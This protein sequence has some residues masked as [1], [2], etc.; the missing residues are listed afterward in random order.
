MA[1]GTD[2]DPPV[3]ARGRVPFAAVV[4][5]LV[6]L[7]VGSNLPTPLYP[8][9]A[10]VFHFSPLTLTLVYST[11]AFTVMAGLLVFGSSSDSLGRRRVLVPALVLGTV[12]AGLFAAATNLAWLFVAQIVEGVAMAALQG[13]ALPALMETEP[14]GDVL[15][16]SFVAATA[17][18]G[19]AALGPLVAGTLA[20]YLPWPRQLCFLLVAG[21]TACAA[22]S[23]LR[24]L[25]PDPRPTARWRPARP[26]VPRSMR[27][28]F[29]LASATGG[30]AW[31]VASLFLSLV[32]SYVIEATGSD[33]LAV[34]GAA[35]ALMLACS[36]T[37]QVLARRMAPTRAQL[38]GI[39]LVAVSTIPLV[40]VA[41]LHSVGVVL[42][43][44]VLAGC[45]H[46]LAFRGSLNEIS[47]AAPAGR[48][49]DVVA[50]FFLIVYLATAVPVIGVGLLARSI[51]LVRAVEVFGYAAGAVTAG[52]A[53]VL[54]VR[55][56]RDRRAP[57]GVAASPEA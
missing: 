33:N 23:T 15:R 9:Y 5:A 13:S 45:G 2:L 56:G 35:T 29:L 1:T 6:V 26:T 42:A 11:Y 14:S 50:S 43:A 36:A 41:H 12:A 31:T 53:V 51:T 10:R 46:G 37:V 28:T 52:I 24:F 4:F 38:V 44:S 30:F 57:V 40:L 48:R 18:V 19:G 22:V 32:P 20:E 7:L 55:N 47:T 49:A 3:G 8:T 21:V 54:A 16:A 34:I 39:S 17:T 27:A 25:P